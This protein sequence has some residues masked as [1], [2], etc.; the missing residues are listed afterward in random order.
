MCDYQGLQKYTDYEDNKHNYDHLVFT[1]GASISAAKH[2]GNAKC[3]TVE[4]TY[5][6]V[7]NIVLGTY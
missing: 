5:Q 6:N 1:K 3:N 2:V 4:T 7:D